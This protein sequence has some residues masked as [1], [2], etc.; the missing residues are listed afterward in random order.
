M[1]GFM[2]RRSAWGRCTL[3]S[4]DEAIFRVEMASFIIKRIFV[5]QKILLSGR[6]CFGFLNDLH[7]GRSKL[8]TGLLL[9]VNASLLQQGSIH[10]VCSLPR[11]FLQF[12]LDSCGCQTVTDVCEQDTGSLSCAKLKQCSLPLQVVSWKKGTYMISNPNWSVYILPKLCRWCL[13]YMFV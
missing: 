2:E 3:Y 9:I 1:Q 6:G 12:W 5:G 13:L 4:A 11:R 8:I 7:S 10:L